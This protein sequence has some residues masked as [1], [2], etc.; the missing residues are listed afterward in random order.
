[1]V[2]RT[3]KTASGEEKSPP[4]LL[5]TRQT[6][7]TTSSCLFSDIMEFVENVLKQKIAEFEV[8]M[9]NEDNDAIA[10]HEKLIKTLEKKLSDIQARELSQWEAQSD[11]DPAK[12]MPHHIFQMLNEK[13]QKEKEETE[14]ALKE[15]HRTMPVKV[16]YEQK[17]IKFQTALN[18]LYD[19]SVNV[20]QKNYLLKQCIERIEYYRARTRKT[21]G[22]GTRG[23]WDFSP[24]Q[25][26]VKLKV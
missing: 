21:K 2:Y 3:Y 4:R 13:L 8:E 26:E 11:P 5:C 1:M 15:A 7:C 23:Q 19:D 10:H 20:L 25:M 12:R 9:K 6:F 14:N 22:K 24:I 16:D 18:A 17:I